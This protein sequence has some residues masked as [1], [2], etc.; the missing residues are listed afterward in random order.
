MLTPENIHFPP[1]CHCLFFVL[2]IGITAGVVVLVILAILSAYTMILLIYL[3]EIVKD[4][5]EQVGPFLIFEYFF[6][7]SMQYLFVFFLPP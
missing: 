2:L 3:K 7:D 1:F 4:M 6:S 5:D